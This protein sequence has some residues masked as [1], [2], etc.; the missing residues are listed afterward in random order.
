MDGYQAV[1]GLHRGSVSVANFIVVGK[2]FALSLSSA[3]HMHA[4]KGLA[5]FQRMCMYINTLLRR[6]V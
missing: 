2:S 5:A 1:E 6:G 4:S 3:S